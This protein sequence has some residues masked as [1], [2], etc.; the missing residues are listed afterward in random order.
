MKKLAYL[1]ALTIL[2]GILFAQVVSVN[3]EQC[4]T[5]AKENWPGFRKMALQN[6]NK[7]LVDKTLNKNYLPKLTISG[8]ASYQS[9]VVEFP[10]VPNMD[11]FF[12][13]FPNDNYRTDLQLTQIIYDGG[14]TKKVKDLQ[15]AS[16]SLEESKIEIENYNLMEQI[17]QLYL[18]ILLLQQNH[19]VLLTAKEEIEAN[20]KILQSAFDNG[21]ILNSELNKIKVEK[22]SITKQLMNTETSKLNLIES[23]SVLTG[24]DISAD[25]SFEIPGQTANKFTTLP[26]LKI[27]EAQKDLNYA[28]LE[29]Q[30]RNR[31]PKVAFFANGGLG[32]PGYNFMN[33]D[34]HTYG[35]VGINFSWDIIDWGIYGTQKEKAEIKKQLID[36]DAEAFVKKNSMEVQKINNDIANIIRQITMDEEIV[37]IKMEIKKSS[38]SKFQ[39]GTITSNEYLKDF[40]ELK[41]AQQTLEINKIKLIQKKLALQHQTGIEY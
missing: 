30:Y 19:I 7:A 1:I 39:N 26:Q 14:N 27:F 41:R 8:S 5:A 9:E 37:S 12:P 13:V 40:N 3:I 10:T 32:R 4:R 11:N 35:I 24:L 22:I 34:L 38:W 28:G 25:A 2:P 18:S 21:M 16:I 20:I 23:L 31:F 6:E 29:T 33:T 17:N 36:A 15:Q